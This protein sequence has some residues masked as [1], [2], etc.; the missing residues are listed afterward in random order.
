MS[1]QNSKVFSLRKTYSYARPDGEAPIQQYGLGA[2]Q[3]C[4]N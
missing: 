1:Y 4:P 3:G 2:P